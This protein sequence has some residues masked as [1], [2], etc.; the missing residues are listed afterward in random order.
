MDNSRET[1]QPRSLRI[2][3]F[4]L[5]NSPGLV[6]LAWVAVTAV[7]VVHSLAT[8]DQPDANMAGVVPILQT[9]PWSLLAVVAPILPGPLDLIVFVAV[10]TAGA[11]ANA[12]ILNWICRSVLRLV[13]RTITHFRDRAAL[14]A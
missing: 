7:A 11:V 3:R 9:M 5:R 2:A 1:P 8:W 10:L 13:Q 4:L 12:V 6:Y 14:T